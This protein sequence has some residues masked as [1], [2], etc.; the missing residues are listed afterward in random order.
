MEIKPTV[1][2]FIYSNFMLARHDLELLDS[3]SLFDKGVIDSTAVLELVAF[4]EKTFELSIGDEELVPDNLDSIDNII[5][6]VQRKKG[7]FHAG[8]SVS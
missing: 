4:I 5:N 3:D 7:A 1:R 6:F 8:S 2:D